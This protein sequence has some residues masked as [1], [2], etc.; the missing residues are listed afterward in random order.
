MPA[1]VSQGE[2]P[3]TLGPDVI[4]AIASNPH[5]TMQRREQL[6]TLLDKNKEVFSA[7][8]AA[9]A[10][11]VDKESRLGQWERDLESRRLDLDNKHHA[12]NFERQ[13]ALEQRAAYE[14]LAAEVE[15]QAEQNAASNRTSRAEIEAARTALFNAQNSHA[16]DV[17]A[18]HA[19]RKKALAEIAAAR[20]QVNDLISAVNR[21]IS[22]INA[23]H[24]LMLAVIDPGEPATSSQ[25]DGQPG[26]DNA[27]EAADKETS[28]VR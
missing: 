28:D 2:P 15:Q 23:N 4:L 21:V 22:A 18:F 27:A 9:Q 12:C 3:P 24:L 25:D 14:A 5:E 10:S 7:L 13:K 8:V 26:G 16:D 1:V 20:G 19:E 6:Q 17:A 11:L